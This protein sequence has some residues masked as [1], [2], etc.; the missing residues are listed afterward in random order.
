MSNEFITDVAELIGILGL[1]SSLRSEVYYD[2]DYSLLVPRDFVKLMEFGNPFDPLLRQV[3]P[4]VSE[5]SFVSGFSLNPLAE[6]MDSGLLILKKYKGRVLLML[7]CRCGIHCRFC[8][9]RYMLRGVELRRDLQIPV[10]SESELPSGLEGGLEA[11][12]DSI[13][14]DNSINEVIISGGDPFVQSD[15]QIKKVLEY[16]GKIPHVKRIRIHS[17]YLVVFPKRIT[18]GL[19]EVLSCAKP[20]Y[21]VLHV[22]HPNELSLDFLS[23]LRILSAP[24]KLS[25]TVLLRGVNDDVEVLSKLFSILADNRVIPYYLHQLDRVSGTAHFEVDIIEGRKII[26]ALREQLSGYA[27]PRYVQENAGEICKKILL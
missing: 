26:S 21:L 12:L 1:S 8:F 18:A 16:I 14:L 10:E 24:V 17:R 25:Q 13:M 4:C 19:N 20:V 27:I 11:S 3:L 23:G 22:N 15:R 6:N 5:C 2:S 7:S 9:R